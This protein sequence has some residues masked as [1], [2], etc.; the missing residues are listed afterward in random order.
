[1]AG[2]TEPLV[3]SVGGDSGKGVVRGRG[4]WVEVAIIIT[5]QNHPL[6]PSFLDRKT[7]IVK[8]DIN[9]VITS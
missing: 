7:A 2:V 6:R 4:H 5:S 1:M 3:P 8:F 9:R